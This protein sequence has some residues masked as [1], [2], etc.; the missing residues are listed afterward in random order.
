[1]VELRVDL[2][3]RVCVF[4]KDWSLVYALNICVH[5]IYTYIYINQFDFYFIDM[6][7]FDIVQ[8]YHPGEQDDTRIVFSAPCV[9]IIFIA[10][11]SANISCCLDLSHV[12]PDDERKMTVSHLFFLLGCLIGED[13]IVPA[14]QQLEGQFRL[15]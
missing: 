3:F 10:G 5:Y 6:L 1:M 9:A 2:E 7:L 4:V 13:Y 15:R 11:N 14:L 12:Q 8:P